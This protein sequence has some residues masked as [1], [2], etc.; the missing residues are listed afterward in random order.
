MPAPRL[1]PPEEDA[2]ACA[3]NLFAIIE[4]SKLGSVNAWA[5]KHKLSQTTVNRIVRGTLDPSTATLTEIAKAAGLAAWHLLYPGLDPRHI[6]VA[7]PWPFQGFSR[8]EFDALTEREKGSIE[9]MVRREMEELKAARRAGNPDLSE[10]AYSPA[11]PAPLLTVNHN[12]K[13][14]GLIA[15]SVGNGPHPQEIKEHPHAAP[16]HKRNL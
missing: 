11:V 5:V 3:K 2:R 1:T 15:G 8:T 4:H 12:T 16:R 13:R 9:G 10:N 6:P 7:E 14:G